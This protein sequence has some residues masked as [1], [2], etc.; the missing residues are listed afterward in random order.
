MASDVA[1]L[2]RQSPGYQY[3]YQWI[4]PDMSLEHP[5]TQN[6]PRTRTRDG[7]RNY[8]HFVTAYDVHFIVNNKYYAMK[9]QEKSESFPEIPEI[10]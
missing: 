3:Q 5:D 7:R 9:I 1:E 4:H 10:P 2:R 8:E 6:Q